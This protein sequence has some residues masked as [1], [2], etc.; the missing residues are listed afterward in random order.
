MLPSDSGGVADDSDDEEEDD[1]DVGEHTEII[2]SF[3]ENGNSSSSSV[4]SALSLGSPFFVI[5][6]RI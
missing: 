6:L 1:G 2:M 5:L 4:F 3:D